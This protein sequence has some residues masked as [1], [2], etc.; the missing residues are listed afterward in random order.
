MVRTRE[1]RFWKRVE[2]SDGCWLWIG[3]INSAGYGNVK[4]GELGVQETH[5]ISWLLEY[6]YM[7]TELVLH[8]CDIRPC[9]RPDHLFL[10]SHQDNSDDMI[11]KGRGHWNRGEDNHNAKLSAMDVQEIRARLQGDEQQREIARQFG[12]TQGLISAIKARRVWK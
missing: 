8:T 7:P 5:R 6:R 4:W 11:A 9:V 12:V 3:C 2:K 10:G 1:E